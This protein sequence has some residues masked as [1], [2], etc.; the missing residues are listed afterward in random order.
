M[1]KTQCSTAY[2][3]YRI[4]CAKTVH[5]HT[6]RAHSIVRNEIPWVTERAMRESKDKPRK[7][8]RMKRPTGYKRRSGIM[9]IMDRL[10]SIEH[11]TKIDAY[12]LFRWTIHDLV[13][14]QVICY[15]LA[16]FQRQRI[17]H[18]IVNVWATERVWCVMIE[19]IQMHTVS[20]VYI[21]TCYNICVC[22]W[23][24]MIFAQQLYYASSTTVDE[25]IT[26]HL[27]GATD[28]GRALALFVYLT[29]VLYFVL[30]VLDL[31]GVSFDLWLAYLEYLFKLKQIEKLWYFNHLERLISILSTFTDAK[32]MPI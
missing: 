13:F 27:I 18:L 23:W 12:G 10:P 3:E 15:A 22:A 28:F 32:K 7:I 17:P 1:Q 16:A 31:C 5:T 30:V 26:S 19:L 6:H 25:H 14:V 24:S 9:G 29:V 11:H 21:N 4:A 8:Q 20:F 2:T